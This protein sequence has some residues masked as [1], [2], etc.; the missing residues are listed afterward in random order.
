MR[1]TKRLF[2]KNICQDVKDRPKSFWWYVRHKLK[3]KSGVAPLLEDINNRDSMKFEDRDK[4]N[5]LQKQ[6]LL[7]SRT[8][9]FLELQI[10]RIKKSKRLW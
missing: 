9:I 1:Q 10:E 6:L 2:E 3:T 7:K 4:A 5:I 8:L